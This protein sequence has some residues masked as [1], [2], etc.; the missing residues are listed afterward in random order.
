MPSLTQ[1]TVCLWMKSSDT[2]KEGTPFSYNAPGSP[3]NELL[4]YNYKNFYIHVNGVHRRVKH[5]FNIFVVEV[6]TILQCYCRIKAVPLV[7]VLRIFFFFA[8]LYFLFLIACYT[9]FKLS[10][11]LQLFISVFLFHFASV[12]HNLSSMSH[13]YIC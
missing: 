8:F 11:L 13:P 9:F 7:A 12:S 4:I 3:D 5:S 1:V 10:C 6:Y 2:T